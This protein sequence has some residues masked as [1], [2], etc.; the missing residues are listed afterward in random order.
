MPDQQVFRLRW[1][2]RV[3][4]PHRVEQ[5]KEMLARNDVSLMHE[6][7]SRFSDQVPAH[8]LQLLQVTSVGFCIPPCAT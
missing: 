7:K 5:L 2:G 8:V 6:S 3:S 4:G 1:C